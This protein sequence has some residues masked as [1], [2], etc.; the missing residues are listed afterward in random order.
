MIDFLGSIDQALFLFVNVG[1]ANPVTDFIMPLI[2]SDLLLRVIYGAAIAILLWRGDKRLRWLVL[3]SVVALVFTDQLSSNL[4]KKW[5][6][7]PR[8]CHFFNEINLLV[9]CG[10]GFSIPSS[11]A[12]NLFGQAFLFS[13]HAKV[14]RWYLILFASLVALSRI[15]V[16]VHYPF[17]VLAGGLLGFLV[18]S[19]VAVVFAKFENWRL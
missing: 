6:A 19:I 17:D 9:N 3:F 7:R 4:F 18:G 14:A 2:T 11:H 16:G 1:L 8:P 13:Y 10:A 5:I 15:F 12:A